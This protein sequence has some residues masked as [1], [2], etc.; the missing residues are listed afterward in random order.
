MRG[1]DYDLAESFVLWEH[2]IKW[3]SEVTIEN[4]NV[5]LSLHWNII[6]ARPLDS[7]KDLTLH[8]PIRFQTT[9][10]KNRINAILLEMKFPIE[11]KA[12]KTV[13]FFVN[14]V[15]WSKVEVQPWPNFIYK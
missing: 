14:K 8:L 2:R 13:W 7:K 6:A 4:W 15:D 12:F 5:F 11:I 9:T 3:N 10:T 1:V